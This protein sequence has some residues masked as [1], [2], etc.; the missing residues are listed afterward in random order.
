MSEGTQRP[1]ANIGGLCTAFEDRYASIKHKS[2]MIRRLRDEI[3][4]TARECSTI[5]DNI[6]TLIRLDGL[7][8]VSPADKNRI[9]ILR[10]NLALLRQYISE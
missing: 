5:R 10:S 2:A 4:S 1:R 6:D 3:E 7:D 8:S 9:A